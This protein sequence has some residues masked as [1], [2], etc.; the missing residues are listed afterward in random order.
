MDSDYSFEALTEFLKYV[1]DHGLWKANTAL[2]YRTAASKIESDLTEQEAAD[3]RQID[4]N[5]VF[6]RYMNR[7]KLKVS[8]STLATYKRR[9]GNA[10]E[11]FVRYR[12]DPMNYR[13]QLTS[14]RQP[15]DSEKSAP[16]NSRKKRKAPRQPAGDEREPRDVPAMTPSS[17]TPMLTVP[18][19]L[20]PDFLASVQIPR[21]LRKG[22]A[23]RLAA[24]IKTLAMDEA[25]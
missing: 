11:E 19:P 2:S 20:R 17:T 22:E 3:V 13:P 15:G 10:I 1:A 24:F 14:G 21:D 12:G 23:D 16:E 4:L 7:N 8:P 6:Q 9:L 5:L 18:F 25:T